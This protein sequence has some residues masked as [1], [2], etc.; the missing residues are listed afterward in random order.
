MVKA[1]EWMRQGVGDYW[2]PETVAAVDGNSVAL[3]IN[4][5][6]SNDVGV[7]A[8]GQIGTIPPEYRPSF[9]VYGFGQSVGSAGMQFSPN[10]RII[11]PQINPGTYI[12]LSVSWLRGA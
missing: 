7:N 1:A 6:I 4:A 12:K 11:S 2:A 10:G 8:G 3:T 9:M 5:R